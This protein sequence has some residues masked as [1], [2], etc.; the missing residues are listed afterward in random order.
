MI[1]RPPR[2]TLTDTLVPFTS[3]FRSMWASARRP[4]PASSS[5]WRWSPHCLSP[6][7]ASTS[8]SGAP[9]H[10]RAAASCP[11]HRGAPGLFPARCSD[12]LLH[13]VSLLLG[14]RVLAEERQRA[15]RGRSH[16][17]GRDVE[18]G[19]ASCRGRVCQYV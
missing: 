1:Q 11:A 10:E 9:R 4:P 3:L 7:A 6:S 13:R 8:A 16:S 19:R 18:I 12:P 5:W 15:L 14:R 2:S 17:L